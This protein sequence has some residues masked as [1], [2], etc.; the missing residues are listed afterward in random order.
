MGSARYRLRTSYHK[1]KLLDSGLRSL[2]VGFRVE[3]LRP[4]VKGLG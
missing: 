4:R 3:V 1:G 2:G